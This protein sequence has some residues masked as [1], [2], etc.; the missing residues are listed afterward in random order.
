MTGCLIVLVRGLSWTLFNNLSPQPTAT[1]RLKLVAK[2]REAR[3]SPRVPTPP[4]PPAQVHTGEMMPLHHT[5]L[6]TGAPWS[7]LLL[8]VPLHPQHGLAA[9]GTLLDPQ[10]STLVQHVLYSQSHHETAQNPATLILSGE[11]VCLCK[12]ADKCCDNCVS[13]IRH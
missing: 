1:T 3:A 5:N 11:C 6:L 8:H 2:V 12:C 4:A 13:M 10:N 9:L 7:P